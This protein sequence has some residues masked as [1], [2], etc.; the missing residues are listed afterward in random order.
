MDPTSEAL[1]HSAAVIIVL[2]LVIAFLWWHFAGWSEFSFSAG[3]RPSWAPT[4]A[5][6][7][8]SRLRFK[9]CVFSVQRA[10]DP[11]PTS[12]DV[13][14][15]LNNMAIAYSRGNSRFFVPSDF[16]ASLSL[17][18]PLNAFSFT[19]PGFNDAYYADA[20]GAPHG[21]VRDP[22]AAPWCG[23]GGPSPVACTSA[24][25][26]AEVR[27]NLACL[28]SLDP[29]SYGKEC[30]SDADC[31]SAGSCNA[32]YCGT[33]NSCT[34]IPAISNKKAGNPCESDFDCDSIVGSCQKGVCA[35][36]PAVAGVCRNCITDADC[37]GVPGSCAGYS[38]GPDPVGQP[39][40]V[41]L[42][43][44]SRC[45]GGAAVTLTGLV[46]AI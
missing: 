41:T 35:D 36:S 44:C 14:G 32:G 20:D 24:A 8:V 22:T 10:G 38:P 3:D 9:D 7:N 18:R 17:D 23:A 33:V 45:P 40:A 30:A 1:L 6:K 12:R 16:P 43:V 31:G 13:T 2:L 19:I 29:D 46:R 4:G 25:G 28:N 15:I 11:A 37:G 5:H 26:C 42:G 27:A 34:G 21:T 39:C